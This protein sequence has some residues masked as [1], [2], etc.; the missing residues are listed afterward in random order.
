M[1]QKAQMERPGK[2]PETTAW[3]RVASRMEN[4]KL[5]KR[6]AQ[7]TLAAMEGGCQGWGQRAGEA[8]AAA[9][10]KGGLK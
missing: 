7:M 2:C 5:K 3:G 4:R 10:Q 9:V 8:Q 1:L 6:G